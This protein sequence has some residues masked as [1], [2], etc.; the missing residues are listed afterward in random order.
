MKN[1]TNRSARSLIFFDQFV[2]CFICHFDSIRFDG[3]I[4]CNLHSQMVQ[5]VFHRISRILDNLIVRQHQRLKIVLEKKMTPSIIHD[6]CVFDVIA[7]LEQRNVVI[8][9]S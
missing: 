5:D 2:I 1:P 3:E 4:I 9:R 8:K 6:L 7:N